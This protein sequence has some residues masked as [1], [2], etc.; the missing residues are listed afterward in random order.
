MKRKVKKSFEDVT[1]NAFNQKD[2]PRYSYQKSDIS[3][4]Q[5][6][7]MRSYDKGIVHKTLKSQKAVKKLIESAKEEQPVFCIYDAGKLNWLLRI[8]KVDK[9]NKYA[10]I[11]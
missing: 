9:G 7:L 3:I 11:N 4:I 8:I 2:N 6:E 1:I 10:R 5:K